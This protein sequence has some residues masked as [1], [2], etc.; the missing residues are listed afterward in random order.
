MGMDVFGK[1]PTSRTGEHFLNTIWW[2]HPLVRYCEDVAPEV[3]AACDQWRMNDG[4]GLDAER[5]LMLAA[6]LQ[7]ELDSGRTALAAAEL[8]AGGCTT[9]SV[10]N[11]AEWV[12]FLRDCGGFEIR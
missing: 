4:D 2:W 5:A 10:T 6:R 9:F 3:T 1:A 12:E 8:A 7:E 11:V